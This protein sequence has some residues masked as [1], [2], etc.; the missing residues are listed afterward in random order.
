MA[1]RRRRR[2]ELEDHLVFLEEQLQRVKEELAD[3]R[4]SQ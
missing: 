2:D 1:T 3:T 4:P